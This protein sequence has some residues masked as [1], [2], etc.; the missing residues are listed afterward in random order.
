MLKCIQKFIFYIVL[1]LQDCNEIKLLSR[2]FPRS[3]IL[4]CNFH[5][6]KW[7]K[8]VFATALIP[9]E[10]KGE[11]MVAFRGLLFAKSRALFEEA[12][13]TWTEVVKGGR[14][15]ASGWAPG[16]DGLS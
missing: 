7:M 8:T 12:L 2:I 14:S 6:L 4:I 15:E 10:H 11:I 3:R 9:M 13:P 5:S 1:V 16:Q